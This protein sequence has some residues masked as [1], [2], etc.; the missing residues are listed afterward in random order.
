MPLFGVL[1]LEHTRHSNVVRSFE[2]C[3]LERALQY[4]NGEVGSG[5]GRQP[6][7]EVGVWLRHLLQ[8]LL[9]FSQPFH[10]QV[11]VLQHQP[12]SARDRRLQQRHGQLWT[13]DTLLV[14]DRAGL[15]WHLLLPRRQL[16]GLN[17]SLLWRQVLGLTFSWPYPRDR[18]LDRP[19]PRGRYLD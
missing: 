11:A 15:M 9:Q 5:V 14:R 7:A 4:P 17:L 8:F 19:G 18:Y 3:H 10:Q 1:R 2:D 12:L 13:D 6:E 16:N